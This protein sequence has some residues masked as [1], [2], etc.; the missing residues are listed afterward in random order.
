MSDQRAKDDGSDRSL[1]RQIT[2]LCEAFAQALAAGHLPQIE[3]Y[4]H[5][6]P[7]EHQSLLLV[8]LVEH[9]VNFRRQRG[10][11]PTREEYERRYP[12]LDWQDVERST[13]AAPPGGEVGSQEIDFSLSPEAKPRCPHCHHSVELPRAG[14]KLMQCPA[15][16][17]SFR[18]E[19]GEAGTTLEQMRRLGRFE[20]HFRVGRSTFGEVWKAWDTT[21]K[22]FVALKVPHVSMLDDQRY[23]ERFQGEAEAAAQ[24]SHRGIATVYEL[25]WVEKVPILVSEFIEGLSLEQWLK[26]HQP[27]FRETAQIVAEIA[28][29]LDY[30]HATH[31]V[32]RDIKPANIMM[33]EPKPV[34][35][36]L[37]DFGLARRDDAEIAVTLEGQILGT[38]AYMSPEQAR[39][40]GHRA[41]AQ[42]DLYNLGV[43]LYQML[44]G[45][46]PFRGSKAMLI[47][48]ILR[49]EPR[50][51][52]QI[53]DKIPRDLETICLRAMN[54]EP[55]KRCASAGELA[56]ELRKHLDGRPTK[57]RPAG[58]VERTVRWCKR[59]PRL[60]VA[61]GM[62]AAALFAFM[63]VLLIRNY[64][65]G[66]DLA[67]SSLDRGLNHLEKGETNL[68][69][70]WLGRSLEQ[71]PWFDSGLQRV[72][73]TN[74][75]AWLEQ[76]HRLDRILPFAS[77]GRRWFAL[78]SDGQKGVTGGGGEPAQF[79]NIE[80]REPITAPIQ[81]KTN[82]WYPSLSAD[83]RWGVT[84]S[85]EHTAQLWDL[86]RGTPH[87]PG[88]SSDGPM[89][90]ANFNGHSWLATAGELDHT[91]RVWDVN[92]A[93]GT[94]V[95]LRHSAGILSETI[96]DDGQFVLTVGLDKTAR[97][98]QLKA[99]SCLY[100]LHDQRGFDRVG[101]I[102]PGNSFVLLVTS[103]HNVHKYS[104][105]LKKLWEKPSTHQR[106]VNTIR[107]S[108]DSTSFVTLGLDS[109]AILWDARAGKPLGLPLLHS[110][111][112]LNAAFDSTGRL[113]ATGSLDRT[114]RIW[115]A[116]TAER[117]GLP[118]VHESAVWALRFGSDGRSLVTG[119]Q[120]GMAR[121]WR[122]VDV[123]AEKV[124][125][126][127]RSFVWAAAFH[128]DGVRVAIACAPLIPPP[129]TQFPPGIA[130]FWDLQR[131]QPV[132]PSFRHDAT[133]ARLA[134]SRDGKRLATA[135]W[136][137]SARVWDSTTGD[138]LG[139]PL[140]HAD[141]VT[142]VAFHP[143]NRR[144]LTGSLDCK[145]QLWDRE[146]GEQAGKPMVHPA[147]VQDVDLSSDGLYAA[148][149]CSNRRTY[150]WVFG[151]QPLLA[152][153][154][155]HP[156]SVT[157][158]AFTPGGHTVA[159][160]CD[161]RMAR[162]WSTDGRQLLGLPHPVGVKRLA[163][164]PDGKTLATGAADSAVR[165]WDVATGRQM[166]PVLRHDTITGI[167]E[168]V[169][170]LAFSVDGRRL[171]SGG[172]NDLLCL[173]NMPLPVDASVRDLI[174]R[175]KV[176]TA[177]ELDPAG[178]AHDSNL[179]IWRELKRRLDG[180][181]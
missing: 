26:I 10:E 30:A 100:E 32:H 5:L 45:E 72:I 38:L 104:Q 157:G 176:R 91:L 167:S 148:T 164:S 13:I 4:L 154:Y 21:M 66:H 174:E 84:A 112:V 122:L 178:A 8:K 140:V 141:F 173:W 180:D 146:T 53:K 63:A 79:W 163:F 151:V 14:Q 50:K 44:T 168:G 74:L 119:T 125:I 36:V 64:E 137:K 108:P 160:A 143:D 54:K 110:G 81:H 109:T 90:F 6:V 166:G 57:Y 27:S 132:G 161:D 43:V 67:L 116:A 22:R 153:E 41:T 23:L 3:D 48:Q 155:V 111:Q 1:D 113:L 20:L 171:L 47:H 138:C 28:E 120:D 93:R 58:P 87:G 31:V 145:A 135:S 24:L 117:I 152:A 94:G 71:A 46:L 127:Q 156:D 130:Q 15:C 18:V 181:D 88:L 123:N 121:V 7:P 172:R 34:R 33:R 16:K 118:L 175:V 98:W 52:R 42:S 40:E 150:L 35:P 179:S 169:W 103:D 65:Q 69:L 70:L 144:I 102:A 114:V 59:N 75:A 17:G 162:L 134:V 55:A 77:G 78:S 29:A 89:R 19:A 170:A 86:A 9:E 61:S 96:S 149:A 159:T 177:M 101:E 129:K 107:F 99:G 83:G 124:R 60:A 115:D 95:P 49:E 133:I 51:P 136:D 73:R 126:P 158:V 131:Q 97:L 128:P 76:T 106:E 147:E 142:G 11:M 12:G 62:A 39:G 2:L 80:T 56:V 139:K 82:R 85:D 25:Y 165:L 92:K 105:D 68:G 37:I